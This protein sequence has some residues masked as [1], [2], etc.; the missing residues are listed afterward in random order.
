MPPRPRPLPARLTLGLLVLLGVAV[1]RGDDANRLRNPGGEAGDEQLGVDAGSAYFTAADWTASLGDGFV[2][3][4]GGWG[5]TEA[6]DGARFLR[7]LSPVPEAEAFQDVPLPEQGVRYLVLRGWLHGWQT[8]GD[9]AVLT[10]RLLDAA[11]ETIAEQAGEPVSGHRWIERVIIAEPPPAA[12]TARVI[13]R[14]VRTAGQA[15]DGYFD[16]LSLTFHT[17]PPLLARIEFERD[18]TFAPGTVRFRDVSIGPVESRRWEFGDGETSDAAEPVHRYAEPG[19][20]TVRLTVTGDGRE[21]S[22]ELPGPIEVDPLRIVKGPYLQN[23]TQEAVTVCWETNYAADSTL[24]W[25]DAQGVERA[26]TERGAKTLHQMRVE[27]CS[28]WTR[29]SYRVRSRAWDAE[30][31]GEPGTF[32]TAPP[33]DTPFSLVAWGCNHVNPPVFSKLVSLMAAGEPDLALALGDTVDAGSDYEQWERGFFGPLRPLTL[34]VPVAV[35]IGNHEGNDPWFYRFLDQPGNEHWFSFDYANAHLVCVDSNFAFEPGSEQYAWLAADLAS[36][37][38]QAA[39]WLIVGHHHPPWSEIYEETKY[40]ELREHLV[41]LYAEHGVDLLLTAH[42]H[43]YERGQL[44]R[45]D[46]GVMHYIQTS[47]AGGRLWED[48]YEGDWPQVETV[49]QYTYHFTRFRFAGGRLNFEA[50]DIDGNRIDAFE[51]VN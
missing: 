40:A 2:A 28:P 12:R 7:P 1:L 23:V 22:Y 32:K 48:E 21:A 6:F 8:Q 25:T 26:V 36:P 29:A 24:L 30:V 41:P 47:G 38:A 34:N 13:L 20:Y 31:S 27:G 17:E 9:H 50:V 44:R 18:D 10:L 45:P 3:Q 46:G 39:D 11:G 33:R 51:A 37:A 14:A 43:D 35:A 15:A 19:R 4:T 49:I 5:A 16:A 42:I